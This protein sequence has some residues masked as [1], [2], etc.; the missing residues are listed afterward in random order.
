MDTE[1]TFE[2][3]ALIPQ[4][5]R[6]L[7]DEGYTTPSPIQRDAIPDALA[8]RDILA[9]A[10]TGT[11]KTAAFTL[12]M[13]QHLHETPARG[14]NL[15]AL[16]LTPTRE[17]A[18][19]IQENL[20]AYGRHLPLKSTVIV[21]GVAAGPQIA[22][23]R[24]K[25]QILVATPGRLLDLM[26][27]GEVRLDAVEIAILDE[28][29]R[30]LDMG[31]I[32]DV[33]RIVSSLPAKRQTFLASAT[34][35]K[36]ITQLANEM[37][38]DPTR[39]AVAPTSAVADN[40]EQQVL[41]VEKTNK[42]ALLAEVLK[43]QDIDR[44]IVFTRTKHRAN[45]V[46][47]DLVKSGISADAIHSN[48]SQ[49]AR[50]RALGDFDAGRVRVL[51]ATDIVA[52]GI[53]VDDITHVINFEIPNEPESY[54]HRIGRTARAG[55]EGVAM[56]FCEEDELPYVRA[57]ERLTGIELESADDHRFHSDRIATLRASKSG[58]TTR[59]SGSSNG[60]SNRRPNS[61]RASGNGRSDGNRSRRRGR[62]NKQAATAKNS[63]S[64]NRPNGARHGSSRSDESGNRGK[65][66]RGASRHNGNPTSTT[67][68]SPSTPA[69]KNSIS[70]KT[71]NRA[72]K[73]GRG[74]RPAA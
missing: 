34:L 51:V 67:T 21:G 28:A 5:L 35:P 6:A 43:E 33:R 13:L 50:Q 1:T 32:R 61:D 8:G 44:A 20:E 57:I 9:T 49:G 4:L 17:L 2:C 53:D 63:P 7:D 41:F 26:G 69:S 45:R 68:E 12:P 59:S 25:P 55:A 60:S 65:P 38:H 54:V 16:I 47:R 40:I 30:M 19:Q 70:S 74:R 71:V 24:R 11:G 66:R 14:K 46:A 10:Q 3:L 72:A 31:F 42:R 22:K 73:F 27:Q 56:S 23:L 37:L 52:R 15:R 36:E 18:L 62:G 48:K 39:V 29:D 58:A 64:G